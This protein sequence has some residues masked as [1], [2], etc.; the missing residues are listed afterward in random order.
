VVDVREG[1]PGQA[2]ERDVGRARKMLLLELAFREDLEQ[3]GAVPNEPLD[4]V[5]VDRGRH[6]TMLCGSAGSLSPW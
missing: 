5:G 1:I 4:V 3:E 2:L 6:P